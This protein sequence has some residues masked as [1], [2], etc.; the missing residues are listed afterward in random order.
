MGTFEDSFMTRYGWMITELNLMGAELDVYAIVYGFSR[1]GGVF[2]GSCAYLQKMAA[3][4]SR[5]TVVNALASLTKKGLL[6]KGETLLNNQPHPTYKAI[7]HLDNES[8]LYNDCTG[9]CTT[10]VQGDVQPLNRGV[11]N[12][13][14]GGCTIT[15]HNSIS[16]SIP[17]KIIDIIVD[18]IPTLPNP[19]HSDE[20]TVS[21]GYGGTIDMNPRIE[22]LRNKG[23]SEAIIKEAFDKLQ[24]NC[25]KI[26]ANRIRT[27][28]MAANWLDDIMVEANAR[29]SSDD[30]PQRYSI[31][32]TGDGTTLD[33]LP[34]IE[35]EKLYDTHSDEMI[36][37]ALKQTQEYC[38]MKN[39]ERLAKGKSGIFGAGTV[40]NIFSGYLKKQVDAQ[41][42][43]Q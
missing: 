29:N 14:T 32:N 15:E 26:P 1:H 30:L 19:S 21:D 34:R 35:H 24:D 27:F 4:K 31:I 22:Y 10:I 42:A 38:D 25:S 41:G 23:Q 37:A 40:W 43:I 36:T 5:T 18:N 3:V 33:L 11:Y 8:T 7:H 13:C 2:D 39:R 17:E 16:D 6:V 28:T 12:D 20:W 9:G